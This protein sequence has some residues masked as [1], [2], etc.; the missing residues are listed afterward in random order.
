MS[1]E[2]VLEVTYSGALFALDGESGA[3][4]EGMGQWNIGRK[5]KFDDGEAFAIQIEGARESYQQRD[6]VS[7][8]GSNHTWTEIEL[9]WRISRTLFRESRS[10]AIG[11]E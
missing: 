6:R 8:G 7:G 9:R 5:D 1:H 3:I 11:S 10:S 2:R 4:A